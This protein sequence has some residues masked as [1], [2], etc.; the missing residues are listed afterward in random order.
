MEKKNDSKNN[1]LQ[2]FDPQLCLEK[3][4]T[5]GGKRKILAGRL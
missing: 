1:N 4:R 5:M 3:S 2:F